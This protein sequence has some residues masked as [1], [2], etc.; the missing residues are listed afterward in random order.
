MRAMASLTRWFIGGCRR[1]STRLRRYGKMSWAALKTLHRFVMNSGPAI[2]AIATVVI[3]VYA[4]FT[5]GVQQ[6]L[7]V[8]QH[9]IVQMQT[10]PKLSGSVGVHY[11]GDSLLFEY[12]YRLTNI[13]SDTAWSVF[14]EMRAFILCDTQIV[15]LPGYLWGRLVHG[16][17]YYHGS[18][19][20]YNPIAP[21]GYTRSG[22]NGFGSWVAGLANALD[23]VIILEATC[24]YWGSSP[25]KRYEGREYFVYMQMGAYTG[26]RFEKLTRPQGQLLKQIENLHDERKYAEVTSSSRLGLRDMYDSLFGGSATLVVAS[27]VPSRSNVILPWTYRDTFILTDSGFVDF[28]AYRRQFERFRQYEDYLRRK[29]YSGP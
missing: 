2:S 3:A 29:G 27:P 5:Y 23:G 15:Y 21:A 14:D 10:E 12:D 25:I 18:Y 7:R 24:V 26:G 9:D 4:Y 13:G 19:S 17:G 16:P 8:L 28:L 20:S 11:P 22:F 1:L 6:E